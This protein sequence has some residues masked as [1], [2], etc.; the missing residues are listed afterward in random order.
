MGAPAGGFEPP[1]VAL[2]GRRLTVRP[3]RLRSPSSSQSGWPDSNRR[4]PAPKAGGM[5]RLSYIPRECPA[6]VEPA[7]PPWQG[8]RLPIHH[9][10]RPTGSGLSRKAK[11]VGGTLRH[12]ADKWLRCPC[13]GRTYALTSIF[14]NC[15]QRD[16]NLYPSVSECAVSRQRGD[17]EAGGIRTPTYRLK[18]PRCCRYTTTPGIGRSSLRTK[19]IRMGTTS[20]IFAR[21]SPSR[22]VPVWTQAPSARFASRPGFLLGFQARA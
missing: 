10:H 21:P 4:S 5:S 14:N 13:C 7:L 1:I 20:S 17:D 2:T 22:P 9:G 6:G 19:R 8:G 11:Q 3:H 15:R 18:R 12:I 16:S